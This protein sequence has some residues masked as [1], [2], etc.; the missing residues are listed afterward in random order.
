MRQ[1]DHTAYPK[2]LLQKSEA[3][4]RY[5]IQD[6]KEALFLMPECDKAGYYADEINYCAMEISRRAKA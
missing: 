5:I 2:S 4:L 3:S 1:I 6:A